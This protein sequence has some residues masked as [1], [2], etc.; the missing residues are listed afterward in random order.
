MERKYITQLELRELAAATATRIWR[1]LKPDSDRALRAFGVPRGGI[2]AALAVGQHNPLIMVDNAGHADVIIDDL[3]DS[4]ATEATWRQQYPGTP[5]Y[6]LLDKRTMPDKP[7]I[8]FP[9]EG[10]ELGSFEDNITRLLQFVG[11]N[12]LRGGLKETPARVV[13]AW[14]HWC[15]GYALDAKDI[16]KVFEDGGEK[17]DQ[18]VTVKDIPFYS[19]CEHHLAAIFGT[20]SISYI[21][22]GKIVGLSKLSRLVDMYARR[23]QV[24]E[25]LTAQIADALDTQLKP[26]GVGVLVRARHMCMESR[27]VCQ[28]GHHTITTA[29]RGA[30]AR[31][32]DAKAEFLRL[33]E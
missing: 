19:H 5:F 4:G 20:A 28:Q 31:Q 21:P 3:V 1:D 11:E 18:M 6:A 23:L 26:K 33:A 30:I 15:G 24:Q 17:Y 27:G 14:K 2:A 25:R 29:L 9:W 7:W 10:N 32:P 8:I 12:P 22:N 16:L 13:K